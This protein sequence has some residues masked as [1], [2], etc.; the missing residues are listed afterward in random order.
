V[1]CKSFQ[2]DEH[3]CLKAL[4]F[5]PPKSHHR[6]PRSHQAAGSLRGMGIGTKPETSIARNSNPILE[7]R[8]RER[9][10]DKNRTVK[11]IESPIW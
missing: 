5:A 9:Q 8:K 1:R 10:I 11:P 6:I 2:S 3:R 7:S 4:Q